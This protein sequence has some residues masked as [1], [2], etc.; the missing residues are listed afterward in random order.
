VKDLDGHTNT[1]E[2]C[3]QHP[4]IKKVWGCIDNTDLSENKRTLYRLGENK[5]TFTCPLK[6][7]SNSFVQHAVELFCFYEKGV[8]PNAK[9]KDETALYR[10]TMSLLSQYKD[11]AAMWF[12][13]EVEK[14]NKKNK[15]KN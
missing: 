11:E 10:A 1:C 2:K 12:Q 15:G 6:T 8:S 5:N 9:L 3:M 14:R 4:Q 7:I 13:K